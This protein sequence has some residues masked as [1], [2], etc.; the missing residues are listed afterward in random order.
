MNKILLILLLLLI[1]EQVSL[2]NFFSSFFESS[3]IPHTKADIEKKQNL[4]LILKLI[5]SGKKELNVENTATVNVLAL[6]EDN[7][8]KDITKN[9]EWIIGDNSLLSIQNNTIKPIK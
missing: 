9:V 5:Y 6:Y 3:S 2:A 1:F 7:T 4:K 8:T